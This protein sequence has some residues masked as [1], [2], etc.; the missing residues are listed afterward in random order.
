LTSMC[1]WRHF[2]NFYFQ[3]HGGREWNLKQFLSL[4]IQY[5]Y[6]YND[7]FKETKFHTKI[8][9]LWKRTL[10]HVFYNTCYAIYGCKGACIQLP[11]GYITWVLHIHFMWNMFF[12][13]LWLSNLVQ[14]LYLVPLGTKKHVTTCN[15][16]LTIIIAWDFL[17]VWERQFTCTN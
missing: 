1:A 15:N 2:C 3:A 12:Y 7:L 10:Q 11:L 4:E 14:L 17:S 8:Y 9:R 5:I 13:Q 16:L 6:I